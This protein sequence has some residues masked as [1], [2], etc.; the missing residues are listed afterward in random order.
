MLIRTAEFE[1][2]DWLAAA[3]RKRGFTAEW[4]RPH[5]APPS[6]D[7]A[8]VMFDAGA[9]L[10]D[11]IDPLAEL[12]AAVDPAPVVVLTEFPRI[13]E[14]RRALAAGAK[15]VCSKPL[16]IEDLFWHVEQVL[17]NDEPVP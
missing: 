1:M 3:C 5:R 4:L 2:H 6:R 14:F 17:S 13:D 7:T 16:L 12:A 10:E 8:A 11:E 15:A 9:W